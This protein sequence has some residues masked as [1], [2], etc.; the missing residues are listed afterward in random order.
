MSGDSAIQGLGYAFLIILILVFISYA[1]GLVQCCIDGVKKDGRKK[2]VR[3]AKQNQVKTIEPVSE[4]KN[5]GTKI[6]EK[7]LE[8]FLSTGYA[9]DTR[10]EFDEDI[11]TDYDPARMSLEPGVYTSHKNFVEDAYV[12]ATGANATNVIRDDTNEINPRWGLRR[13]DYNTVYSGDNARIVSSE[14]PD[15]MIQMNLDYVL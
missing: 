10:Q 6:E 4:A 11:P 9:E 3:F 2:R 7:Q 12:S 8:K 15:Q 14:F 1:G 13:V 5:D